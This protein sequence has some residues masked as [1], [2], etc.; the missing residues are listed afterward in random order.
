M[1]GPGGEGA[2]G[3]KSEDL[4]SYDGTRDEAIKFRTK[5]RRDPLRSLI[6]DSLYINGDFNIVRRQDVDDVDRLGFQGEVRSG[7]ADDVTDEGLV[8][9]ESSK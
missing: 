5:M 1:T 3:T 8:S 7:R 9:R 6:V 4:R 2:H